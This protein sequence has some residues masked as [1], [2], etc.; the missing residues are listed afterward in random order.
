MSAQS[1]SM[2]LRRPLIRTESM[3]SGSM[4]PSSGLPTMMRSRR[5]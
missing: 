5:S 4:K 3:L 2:R 1:R